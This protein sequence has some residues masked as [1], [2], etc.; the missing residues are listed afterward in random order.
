MGLSAFPEWSSAVSTITVQECVGTTAELT[1]RITSKKHRPNCST[2]WVDMIRAYLPGIDL[3][4]DT[5][6]S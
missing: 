3:P 4:I 5:L 2:S 1:A 6:S